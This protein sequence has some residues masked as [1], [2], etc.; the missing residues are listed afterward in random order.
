MEKEQ[1]QLQEDYCKVEQREQ[2]ARIESHRCNKQVADLSR[3]IETL[4]AAQNKHS[5]V[6][7]ELAAERKVRKENQK[8]ISESERA[9]EQFRVYVS[10]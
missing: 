9:L 10:F 5:Q 1:K 7:E 8:K 4:S 2:A 6:D 3:Q